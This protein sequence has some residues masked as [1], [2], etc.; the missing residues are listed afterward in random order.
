MRAAL[1]CTSAA[2]AVGIASVAAEAAAV[3]DASRDTSEEPGAARVAADT[4]AAQ[5]SPPPVPSPTEA[6]GVRHA[7]LSVLSQELEKPGSAYTSGI[8]AQI[9]ETTGLAEKP[10]RLELASLLDDLEAHWRDRTA[11]WK[12]VTGL[13]GDNAR[14][15]QVDRLMA[16]LIKR[17]RKA[18]GGKG[19]YQ[20][21]QLVEQS[22]GKA[23]MPSYLAKDLVLAALRA[24]LTGDAVGPGD[25]PD[26]VG[27][28]VQGRSAYRIE[29]D[30]FPG[31]LLTADDQLDLTKVRD[32]HRPIGD[33]LVEALPESE[34]VRWALTESHPNLEPDCILTFRIDELYS[35]LPYPREGSFPMVYADIHVRLEHADTGTHLH[36]AL[37]EFSYDFFLEQEPEVRNLRLLD[38]V[39]RKAAAEITGEVDRYLGQK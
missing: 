4:G 39:Y 15:K 9:S 12:T 6:P 5:S 28:L 34:H 35:E 13:G 24:G 16:E 11:L 14:P 20:L 25:R 32:A 38:N 29:I 10:L 18:V 27:I 22:A 8:F 36:Q 31:L 33:L 26:R 21:D 2:L 7:A 37:V 19:N 23:R 1:L 30:G 17:L 3:A